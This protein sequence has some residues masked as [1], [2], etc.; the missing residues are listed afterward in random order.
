MS[1]NILGGKMARAHG[2]TLKVV[3]QPT[4]NENKDAIEGMELLGKRDG[5]G[6]GN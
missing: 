3:I 5:L 6:G 4:R 1:F 2:H